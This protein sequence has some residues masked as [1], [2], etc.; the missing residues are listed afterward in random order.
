MKINITLFVQIFNFFVA[1]KIITIFFLSPILKLIKKEDLEQEELISDVASQSENLALKKVYKQELWKECQNQFFKE[2]PS[3]DVFS[4]LKIENK[5]ISTFDA[6][7]IK[8][9][10]KL[11]D[12]VIVVLKEK[13]KNDN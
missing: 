8:F 9:S 13:I 4:K 7:T 11:I 6:S 2:K 10:D 5:S 3:M 12:E 1:Y